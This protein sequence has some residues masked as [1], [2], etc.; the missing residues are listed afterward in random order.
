MSPK[1]NKE[2]AEQLFGEIDN[3]GFGYWVMNYGFKDSSIDPELTKLCAEA[4]EK[5]RILEKY[6]G[7]VWG[8]Y[9][10]G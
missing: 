2:S 3:Q 8:Y 9:N 7:E 1:L 4:K 10:I 5:M 6:I